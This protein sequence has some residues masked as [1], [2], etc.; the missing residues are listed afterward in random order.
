LG[1]VVASGVLVLSDQLLLFCVNGNHRTVGELKTYRLV[2]DVFKLIVALRM[3]AA[4][5]GLAIDLASILQMEEK[6]GDSAG[7]QLMSQLAQ[8]RSELL[9][10]F[11]HPQKRSHR[12]AHRRRLKQASQVLQKRRVSAHQ[13]STAPADTPHSLAK[14]LLSDKVTPIYAWFWR[15]IHNRELS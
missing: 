15:A 10:T 14:S 3:D 5:F 11:R 9:M 8:L 7:A 4:L 12:V 1:A 2:V 6:F 13:G